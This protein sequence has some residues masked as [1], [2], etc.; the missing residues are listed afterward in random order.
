MQRHVAVGR[1]DKDEGATM[2]VSHLCCSASLL[3]SV[4][5]A[6]AWDYSPASVPQVADGKEVQGTQIPHSVKGEERNGPVC[7][8]IISLCSFSI[9]QASTEDDYMTTRHSGIIVI[10]KGIRFGGVLNLWRKNM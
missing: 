6:T 4:C 7:S 5:V 10:K 2:A 8:G 3:P 9:L 1:E